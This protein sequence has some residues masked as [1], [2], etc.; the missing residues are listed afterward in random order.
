MLVSVNGRPVEGLRNLHARLEAA[1][2][3]GE[4]VSF[5]F[6][7]WSGDRDRGYDYMERSME[8]DEFEFVGP[9]PLRQIA[10]RD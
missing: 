10:S 6:K 2:R 4:A 7:R 9:S 8:I 1:N 3:A 5:V